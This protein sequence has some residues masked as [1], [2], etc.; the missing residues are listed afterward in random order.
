MSIGEA[1]S[2]DSTLEVLSQWAHDSLEFRKDMIGR[3]MLGTML[4]LP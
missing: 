2:N 3:P 1:T 4:Q